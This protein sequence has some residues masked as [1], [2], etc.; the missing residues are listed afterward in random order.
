MFY[1][2]YT[3]ILGQ[4]KLTRPFLQKQEITDET[5]FSVCFSLLLLTAK[6]DP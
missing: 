4:K 1:L 3:F 2:M 6:I 5:I